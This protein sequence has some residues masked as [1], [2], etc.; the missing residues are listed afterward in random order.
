MCDKYVNTPK[1]EDTQNLHLEAYK[2]LVEML[3]KDDNLSWQQNGILIAINGG[4]LTALGSIQPKDPSI[5]IQSI[6][7]ISLIIC[8]LG[9]VVCF[10]WHLI[11]N[12]IESFYNHWF[13][14]LKYLE[15]TELPSIKIFRIADKFFEDKQIKLGET[16]F[17]LRLM[18][19]IIKMF[20]II[21]ILTVILMVTWIFLGIFFI[22]KL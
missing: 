17:K 1:K 14:Q 9:V 18:S 16:T 22:S 11:A 7:L 6:N 8:A 13:E 4:L 3:K 5:T 15:K 12:R 21:Q 10:F 19:R 2:I 20:T